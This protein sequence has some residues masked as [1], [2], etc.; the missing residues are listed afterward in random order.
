MT[1][2]VQNCQNWPVLPVI[3]ECIWVYF[4]RNGDF[5]L[6]VCSAVRHLLTLINLSAMIWKEKMKLRSQHKTRLD[7]VMWTPSY[8]PREDQYGSKL[9]ELLGGVQKW[10]HQESNQG[11]QFFNFATGPIRRYITAVQQQPS[12][13]SLFICKLFCIPQQCGVFGRCFRFAVFWQCPFCP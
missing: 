9:P 12:M 10:H 13:G 7:V 4:G 5:T 1:N 3:F 11:L 8:G 2:K 6:V